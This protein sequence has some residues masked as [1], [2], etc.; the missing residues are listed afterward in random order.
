MMGR[1]N[2][3]SRIGAEIHVR[4]ARR[5]AQDHGGVRPSPTIDSLLSRMIEFH[6]LLLRLLDHGPLRAR[7]AA[8]TRK[9]TPQDRV[10]RTSSPTAV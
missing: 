7:R 4:C 2:V 3:G 8:P 5:Q 6:L 9:R 10:V 1:E